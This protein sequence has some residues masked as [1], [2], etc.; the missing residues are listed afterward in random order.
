MPTTSSSAQAVTVVSFRLQS[1]LLQQLQPLGARRGP[2][3]GKVASPCEGTTAKLQDGVEVG[4][5]PG[6]GRCSGHGP[7]ASSGTNYGQY[8]PYC[9]PQ[10]SSVMAPKTIPR[11]T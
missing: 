4:L 7:D 3:T 2:Y 9:E 8:Q 10:Y 6:R 1:D 11:H 5:L